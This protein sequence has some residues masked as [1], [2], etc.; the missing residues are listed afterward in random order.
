MSRG[1]EALEENAGPRQ[2]TRPVS[3]HAPLSAAH[4]RELKYN[5]YNGFAAA[6]SPR[7]GV[8]CDVNAKQ[9]LQQLINAVRRVERADLLPAYGFDTGTSAP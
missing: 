6:A 5:R 8:G 9:T 2:L 3:H 7:H 4:H 1:V